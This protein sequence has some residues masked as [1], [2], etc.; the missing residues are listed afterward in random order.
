MTEKIK[1]YLEFLKKQDGKQYFLLN[2]FYF[3]PDKSLGGSEEETL[4]KYYNYGD[5]KKLVLNNNFYQ[6]LQLCM[7]DINFNNKLNYNLLRKIRFLLCDTLEF[8]REYI[9]DLEDDYLR[10]FC[11]NEVPIGPIYSK[12][13]SKLELYFIITHYQKIGFIYDQCPSIDKKDDIDTKLIENLIWT[14]GWKIDLYYEE[15]IKP[16]EERKS[17][18]KSIE[19]DNYNDQLNCFLAIRNGHD[20]KSFHSLVCNNE[21]LNLIQ[22]VLLEKELSNIVI[23]N[24]I[25]I[26]EIG[27]NFKTRNNIYEDFSYLYQKLGEQKIKEFDYKR[28][29]N[30]ITLLTTKKKSSKIIQLKKK[31]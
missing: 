24:I 11:G 10:K 3:F 15:Y 20:K 30:L 31:T 26:L 6:F 14:N 25:E 21:F 22:N 28:A 23:D 13:Y 29:M 12:K 18:L 17:I 5:I 19:T 1:K 2:K 4:E 7:E 8:K 9:S 27:I 16:I